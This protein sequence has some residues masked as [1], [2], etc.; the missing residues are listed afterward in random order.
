MTEFNGR[1]GECDEC[2]EEE[3]VFKFEDLSLCEDCLAAY[4]GEEI[5]VDGDGV[6]HTVEKPDWQIAE[7]IHSD[8]EAVAKARQ[9]FDRWV[10]HMGRGCCE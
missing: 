2:G 9:A 6:A 10:E 7:E 3:M 4:A 5:E 1:E 8:A